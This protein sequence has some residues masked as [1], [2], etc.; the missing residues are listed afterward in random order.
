MLKKEEILAMEA[1]RKLDILV[2]SEIFGIEVEWDY[3]SWD[4]NKQL[5]KQPFR[6]GEPRTV[7]G[8]T[9]HVVLNT[10]FEHSTDIQAAWPV[11]EK[12]FELGH[13]MSLL[14]LSSEFY[15]DYW[16]CDFRLKGKTTPPEYEWVD[17]ISKAPEAI[18]KAALISKLNSR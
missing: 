7:L 8:P 16:Y 1:G 18:C 10:I 12:M 15:P 17:H 2:A 6:K 11:V 4:I 9:A 14:H 13:S 3:S 5:P